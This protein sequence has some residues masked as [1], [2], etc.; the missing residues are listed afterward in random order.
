MTAPLP[1]SLAERA[2]RIK[3]LIVDVDGVLT[4]GRLYINAHGEVSKAFHTLDGHGIKMLQQSG[5]PTAVITARNDPAVRARVEQLGIAHYLCGEHD[6]KA[7][8]ARLRGQIGLHESACAFVGDDV[9]D[10]PVMV[11]CGLPV[12]VSNAHDFVKRH[13][14]YTTRASGGAGA[15]REVCEL[16]LQAQGHLDALLA[17]YVR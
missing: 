1:P 4:D 11:R 10:L 3:L 2:A 16:I 7:A 6:K 13:A 9:I 12:A 8:Y 15:V 17:E 14:A 5:T